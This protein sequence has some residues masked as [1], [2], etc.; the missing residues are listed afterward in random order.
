M[1]ILYAIGYGV[2]MK[3]A[4]L[5]DEHGLKLFRGAPLLFG[6]AWGAF[7]V[8]LV[9]GD[10]AVANVVLAMN[11][12]FIIRNRLDYLNHR[13]AAS[14]II[15]AFLLTSRFDPLL[16]LAFYVAFLAFGSIKDYLDDDVRSSS[17]AALL[18]EAMLYYPIPTLIYCLAYGNW[19]VFWVFLAYTI[20][21]N[22]TKLVA[23][24]Y[25][26]R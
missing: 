21:Y 20:S 25:S 6:L 22:V 8:A 13:I 15:V 26:Y 12:A 23:R 5:L 18:S 11:V 14:M 16:F 4:D 10:V 9:A 19:I 2:T 3:V 17:P 24:R 1:L 7:G